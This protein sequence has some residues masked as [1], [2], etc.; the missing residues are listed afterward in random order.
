[1]IPAAGES[2][3]PASQLESDRHEHRQCPDIL[4]EG[5]KHGHRAD[6]RNDLTID[7]G[8]IR[9]DPARN[10]LDDARARD[11]RAD[12]QCA[13]NNDDYIVAKALEGLIGGYDANYYSRKQRDRRHKVVPPPTPNE[14]RHHDD[15]DGECQPLSKRHEFL[16]NPVGE[17]LAHGR[18]AE[19]RNAPS[20]LPEAP[21]VPQLSSLPWPHF[22]YGS[23]ADVGSNIVRVR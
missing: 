16:A 15:D 2:S 23:K 10:P 20:Q 8:E 6:Q 1:M 3:A 7:V 13:A 21:R 22:R 11:R 4:D 17:D 9:A 18:R 12:H 14:Q 5:R 19:A